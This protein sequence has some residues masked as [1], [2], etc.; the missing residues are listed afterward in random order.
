MHVRTPCDLCSR[1][2]LTP[3]A[4]PCRLVGVAPLPASVR[5]LENGAG[6]LSMAWCGGEGVWG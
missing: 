1:P 5:M 6:M 4:I 3:Q 2:L